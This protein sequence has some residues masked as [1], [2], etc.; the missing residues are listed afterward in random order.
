MSAPMHTSQPHADGMLH[1]SGAAR[2]VDDLPEPADLL[3]AA[4][5][6][7]PVAHG[8]LRSVVAPEDPDLVALLRASDIP[9]EPLI[10]AIVHDEPLLA[11]GQVES[12]GQPVAL[13]LARTPEAAEALARTVR[14]EVEPLPAI[15][16][17]EAA[18]AAESFS[19]G[20]HIIQTGDPASALASATHRLSGTTRSGAQ[21]HFYL[22]TQAALVLPGEAGDWTVYSSTQH[23]TEI[24]R[25]VALVLGCGQHQV[26]C[27]VPRLGGGFGGK[28][29]QASHTAA[30][31]ALGA[32]CTGRPV[33][34][35]LERDVDALCTGNRHPFLSR[36]EA[37]F[38]DEGR[39]LALTAEV[40]SD[41]GYTLDLS[42]P[43]LDRALFH[44]D[45][46]Y[47]IPNLRV[48]GRVCKTHTAS[49]TAFR[50]FG[51][52]QGMLVVEDV[53]HPTHQPESAFA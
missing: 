31:A 39:L 5:V 48:M 33:K 9:G 22:E 10:G 23:P 4:V 32:F 35:R 34:L 8:R 2:Y 37:G 11:D 49:N 3:H 40:Y 1:V 46:C 6:L 45:N 15:V 21:N 25:M 16:G 42:G 43:V 38:D 44:L 24:Q 26:R 50:G 13:V 52:P 41:G 36:W 28:E 14:V 7:S 51:G 20:P 19:T 53:L 12:V 27:E 30:L 18:L 17:I 47:A 29:S